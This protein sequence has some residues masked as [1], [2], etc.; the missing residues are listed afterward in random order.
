VVLRPFVEIAIYNPAIMLFVTDDEAAVRSGG[1]RRGT[2]RRTDAP[3]ASAA[4]LR[5]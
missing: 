5:K 3:V 4:C 2:A 1:H